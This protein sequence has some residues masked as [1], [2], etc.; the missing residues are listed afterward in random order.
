MS[1]LGTNLGLTNEE[2][3]EY[4]EL[5]SQ[6][7]TQFPEL[8][9]GYDSLGKPIIKAATDVDTLKATLKTQ[10]VNQYTESVKNAKDVIDKLNAEVNQDKNWFWEEAGTDQQLQSLEKFQSAYENAFK[11]KDGNKFLDLNQWLD[12]GNFVDA[13]ES[14]HKGNLKLIATLMISLILLLDH[15]NL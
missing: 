15:K 2:Y 10:K 3:A 14:T 7:A 8:V 11:N 6:I 9:S 4:Q 5:A 1:S 12:D 13:L